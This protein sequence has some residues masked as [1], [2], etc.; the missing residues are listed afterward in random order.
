MITPINGGNNSN[1]PPSRLNKLTK[2]NFDA[3][4][5]FEVLIKAYENDCSFSIPEIPEEVAIQVNMLISGISDDEIKIFMAN[6]SQTKNFLN[7]YNLAHGSSLTLFDVHGLTTII[8]NGASS[9]EIEHYLSNAQEAK[10][11]LDNYNL[12]YGVSL[13]LFMSSGLIN[14]VFDGA[15]SEKIE[16]YLRNAQKAGEIL[17]EYNRINGTR[18]FRSR[19]T[20]YN[21][22]DLIDKIANG[23]SP[24]EIERY[25]SNA[26][27]DKMNHE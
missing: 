1:I 24:G 6:V 9:K 3:A 13:S 23:A 5:E 8:V 27:Q 22:P 18:N 11:I 14:K 20:F 2:L 25:L 12:E 16:G 21:V 15:S 4:K 26:R 17:G 19:L 10:R 7:N